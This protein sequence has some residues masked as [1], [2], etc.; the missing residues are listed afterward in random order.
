MDFHVIYNLPIDLK[1]VQ[2][3]LFAH[4]FNVLDTKYIQDSVDNSPYNSYRNSPVTGPIVNPH[5]ADAAEVYFGML[6]TFNVGLAL[7]Y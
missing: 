1:G 2:L 4:V 6:R 5:Q 7:N 3:Q